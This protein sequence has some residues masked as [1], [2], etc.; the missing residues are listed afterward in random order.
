MLRLSFREL[1]GVSLQYCV[2]VYCVILAKGGGMVPQGKFAFWLYK[3]V[4]V[5]NLDHFSMFVNPSLQLHIPYIRIIR[6]DIVHSYS[7]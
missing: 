2:C 5:V 6:T 7:M 4:S 1:G 3:V